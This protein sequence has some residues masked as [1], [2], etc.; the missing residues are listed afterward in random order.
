MISS[1]TVNEWL[2]MEVA[3]FHSYQCVVQQVGVY[4]VVD[5][6]GEMIR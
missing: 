6:H 1:V 5:I 4:E 2:S 3:Y